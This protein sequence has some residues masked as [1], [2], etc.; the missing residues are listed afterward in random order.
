MNIS[1]ISGR[2]KWMFYRAGDSIRK[3]MDYKAVEI[4]GLML[5]LFMVVAFIVNYLE[6][7]TV[8][9]PLL[10]IFIAG[11]GALFGVAVLGAVLRKGIKT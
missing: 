5:V 4:D 8:F 10:I 6:F 7:G 9:T 3:E 1:E 2:G 11:T